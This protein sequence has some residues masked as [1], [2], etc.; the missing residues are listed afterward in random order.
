MQRLPCTFACS[1]RCRASSQLQWVNP[2]T[3][4]QRHAN[5][6]KWQTQC[7]KQDAR[8]GVSDPS[9][10]K[11]FIAKW[12]PCQFQRSVVSSKK[13]RSLHPF[14]KMIC[15][16]ACGL[17]CPPCI[18]FI[19]IAVIRKPRPQ[20]SS[21]ILIPLCHSW[22]QKTRDVMLL[23]TKSRLIIT[24]PD[25]SPMLSPLSI[26]TLFHTM[27]ASNVSFR[28]LFRSQLL[29]N[30]IEISISKKQDVWW[31]SHVW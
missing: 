15:C 18:E 4:I 25:D 11:G 29:R 12:W 22:G 31:G 6:K 14:Y 17:V 26:T 27:H 3:L 10:C 1:P 16:E 13:R 24:T 9:R 30:I 2:R 23:L 28:I 19:W 20:S 8:W 21:T 7:R 5:F